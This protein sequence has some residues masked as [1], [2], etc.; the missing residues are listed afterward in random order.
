[1]TISE[2]R[3]NVKKH[4]SGNFLKAI[5]MYALFVIFAIILIIVFMVN[6]IEKEL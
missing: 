5:F 4:L 1:M 6:I 2:L 3:S